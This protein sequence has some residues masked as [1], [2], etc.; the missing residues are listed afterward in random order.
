MV[1]LEY[2]AI[3]SAADLAILADEWN[4][5]ARRCA[6]YHLSQTHRWAEVSWQTIAQPR[7]RHLAG[8]ALR[9]SGR[10][11][12]IW[13]MVTYRAFG[14]RII[15]PL[16]S[17]TT[18]Y[19]M[20]LV[21]P[22]ADRAGWLEG[23][24]ENASRSADVVMLPHLSVDSELAKLVRQDG[25]HRFVEGAT[26]ALW[27][28]H[29]DHGNWTNYE[30]SLSSRHVAEL[31]RRRRRLAEL[32]RVEFGEQDASRAEALIDWLLDHKK[33]WL[34]NK[35]IR[36]E[37]QAR[38]DYRS[39]LVGLA[40]REQPLGRVSPFVLTLNGEPIAAQL[41]ILTS[42]RVESLIATYD[43][44]YRRYAVG[45]IVN[46]ECLRWALERGLD[47]DFRLGDQSFKFDWA[48]RQREIVSWLV[49]TGA[50]GWPL[51]AMLHARA[52]A[53]QARFKLG[54]GRLLPSLRRKP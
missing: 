27:V 14:A 12:A 53:R 8:V 2:L 17:E 19:C 9:S 1:A 48:Q 22:D 11:V 10:L 28:A 6:G 30:S 20:P 54:L 43:A 5:L 31:R 36:N 34:L 38:S 33:R 16:G 26:Q 45:N 13:P 51:F 47:Y 46:A 25:R 15:R 7:G 35:N 39:F 4:A 29:D 52:A 24:W 21:E 42:T 41:N 44:K 49:L 32:G 18:E 50:R 40:S 37:W 23:L 3:R